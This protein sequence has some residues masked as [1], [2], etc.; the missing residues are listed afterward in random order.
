[1]N[2]WPGRHIYAFN[3]AMY[4]T[5]VA[6]RYNGLPRDCL[7]VMLRQLPLK[8]WA[9]LH[10]TNKSHRKLTAALVT[11]AVVPLSQLAQHSIPITAGLPKLEDITIIIPATTSPSHAPC[12]ISSQHCPTSGASISPATCAAASTQM[13]L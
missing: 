9:P 12:G 10:R 5:C 6:E 11:H 4:R 2:G 7:E 13:Q 8:E 1:M 3:T